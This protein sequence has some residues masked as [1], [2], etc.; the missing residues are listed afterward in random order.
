MFVRHEDVDVVVRTASDRRQELAGNDRSRKARLGPRKAVLR[1]PVRQRLLSLRSAAHRR[2]V[3]RHAHVDICGEAV[4]PEPSHREP[5]PRIQQNTDRVRNR[6]Q[7]DAL[8]RARIRTGQRARVLEVID[9]ARALRHRRRK[10]DPNAGGCAQPL[11]VESVAGF[12]GQLRDVQTVVQF[13]AGGGQILQG[14]EGYIRRSRQLASGRIYFSRNDIA[15][16]VQLLPNRRC[17]GGTPRAD[18]NE[19]Q[20]NR[21][22]HRRANTD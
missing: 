7:F 19:A 18:G 11:G 17:R 1:P 3:L 22:N 10:R 20:N 13:K 15:G 21:Q 9:V 8:H 2:V 6:R 12:I 5:P 14:R 4:G 16:D